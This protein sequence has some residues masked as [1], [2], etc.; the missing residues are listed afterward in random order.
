MLPETA[1]AAPATQ[2]AAVRTAGAL[3]SFGIVAC[4]AVLLAAA[5]E[6]QAG[7]LNAFQRGFVLTGWHA[8]SYET[9]T[10]DSQLQR[11]AANGSDRAAIFTQWFMDTPTSSHIAPDPGRTPSDAAMVHAIAIARLHGMQVTIKPQIGIRTDSWIGRAHPAD[12]TAFWAD[13]RLMLLHYAELAAQSGATMLVIG[14]EMSTLSWDQ[15]H[16]RP[17]IAEIRA[18][19]HGQLTYAANYDEYQRVP[20]WD[21]LDLIGIDGYLP[22]AD[23]SNPAPSVQELVSAWGS[24]GYLAAIASVSQRTGKRVLFTELGYRGGHT[25]AVHPNLWNVADVTDTQ[26]QANAYEAFYEAVAAQPWFAGIYW[27]E[28]NPDSWWVQDYNPIGKPAEQVVV[29]W[30]ARASSAEVPSAPSP[31]PPPPQPSAA[32]TVRCS[33]YLTWRWGH[34]RLHLATA[35]THR[36]P[37]SGCRAPLSRE[38]CGCAPVRA[39]SG[40]LRRGAGV[41]REGGRV[42]RLGNC[43]SRSPT[44]PAASLSGS[45]ASEAPTK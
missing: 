7:T 40:L 45:R 8:G 2:N 28:V 39:D 42:R 32:A 31:P 3:L 41:L 34:R 1:S 10:S 44:C 33:P 11:M 37:L 43:T 17:L 30:N 20:F 18:R 12:L 21:A 14:T 24:R 19:F 6:A 15:A 38:R 26:A 5:P 16:W 29:A 25:T 13:Y 23:A 9:A 36:R 27:W 4:I 22:L 35:R